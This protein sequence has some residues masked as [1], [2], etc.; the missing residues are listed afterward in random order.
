[1]LLMRVGEVFVSFEASGADLD[2]AACGEGCPLEVHLAS[3][4]ARWIELGCTRTV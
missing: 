1:M 2:A 3:A 4:L